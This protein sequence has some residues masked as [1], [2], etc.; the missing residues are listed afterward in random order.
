MITERDVEFHTPADADHHWAETN[1]FCFYIAELNLVGGIYTCVRKGLGSALSEVF[2]FNRLTRERTD[3]VYFDSMAHLPA[4]EKLSHYELANGL[5]VT[6]VGP[7]RDY[8]IDYRGTNGMELHLDFAGLME[9][10]DIHDPAMSPTAAPTAEGQVEGSGFGAG[11]SGHFDLSGRVTGT[12]TLAGT[13]YPVD[14]VD[15]MDHSWGPRTERGMRAMGWSG[16]HFGEEYVWHGIWVKDPFAPPEDEF[17][18]ANG[19]VLEDGKVLGLASGTMVAKREDGL[20]VHVDMHLIDRDGRDHHITGRARANHDWVPHACLEVHDVFYE[21]STAGRGP[22]Y[23]VI[24]EAIP[25]D[26]MAAANQAKGVDA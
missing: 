23:G 8:R 11:Y 21:Y 26:L 20:A 15:S 18:I 4:P 5:T 13:T 16:G 25:L 14:C 2:I 22:G 1:Q 9:P 12:L 24:Q 6:A 3:V 7:P 19:Y 10:Y 17:R